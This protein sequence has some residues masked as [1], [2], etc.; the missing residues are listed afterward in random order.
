MRGRRGKGLKKTEM[1]EKKEVK[2]WKPGLKDE[3]ERKP[4]PLSSCWHGVEDWAPDIR[5][6]EISIVFIEPFAWAAV[7][8]H[9]FKSF[10]YL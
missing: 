4:P 2:G 9:N 5:F 6:D 10:P 7:M 8:A 1:G 3:K